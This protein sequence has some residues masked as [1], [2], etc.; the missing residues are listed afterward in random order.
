MTFSA[1]GAVAGEPL[2][3]RICDA[4][5]LRA[6]AEAERRVAEWLAHCLAGQAEA[7][8]A[9]SS[10]N[11]KLD[12][13]LHG[14]AQYSPFLFD[15]VRAD[16][17][18]LLRILGSDPDVTLTRLIVATRAAIEASDSDPDVMRKLRL[19]KAEAALLIALC[20]IGGVWPVMRVTQALT[21]LAIASVQM[22]LR[23]LLRGEV[24]RGRLRLADPANPEDDSGLIVLAM[25]KMGAGELNYSSDID[26][27]V[28][29]D[30]DA[31]TLAD[32]VEPGPFFV[33]IGRAHV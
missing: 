23:Y 4:P 7:L 18:R 6:P 19:M 8:R 1:T 15:L 32:G 13:A 11:P 26:L 28:F 21:E 9:L 10:S 16:P 12:A 29:Y 14:I 17:S 20:D 22:A 33:Q 27:I 24:A 31:P 30:G 25:G 5:H 2:A 3:V